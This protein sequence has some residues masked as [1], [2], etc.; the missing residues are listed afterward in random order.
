L[1]PGGTFDVRQEEV[2]P[3]HWEITFLKVNMKGKA[4]FFKT[5]NVQQNEM[6]S[7]FHQ[8]P[9]TLT[10]MQAMDLLQKQEAVPV[11]LGHDS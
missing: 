10:L 5:I 2:A 8:V 11:T 3:N 6:R 7:H 4:L 9:E 1:D